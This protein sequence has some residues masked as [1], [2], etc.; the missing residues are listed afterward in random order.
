M[1]TVRVNDIDVYYEVRGE[2]APLVLIMGLG[3]DISEFEHMIGWLARRYRVLAFDNRGAGRTDKPD[4]PYSVPMMADDTVGVMRAAG[5]EHASVLGISLGGRIALDVGL[6]YPEMVDKLV[7]VSTSA[8]VIDSLRRKVLLGLF[9]RLPLA[10]G[11]HPQPRYAFAR[12]RT[13]SGAYNCVTRLA[14]I[15]APTTILHGRSDKTAPYPLAEELNH[16]IPKSKL[17]TFDG[18]HIFFLF[19]ERERFLTEVA[20]FLG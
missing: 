18:G 13:A 8:R 17:I 3:A 19:R 4:T 15:S 2:G 14:E 16:G 12:Q 7:L 5:F 10:R 1:P 11:A 6:R 20:H 9:S